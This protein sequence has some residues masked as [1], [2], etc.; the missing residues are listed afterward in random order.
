MI[1]RRIIVAIAFLCLLAF[2]IVASRRSVDL[3]PDTF[4]PA[5]ALDEFGFY[6]RRV[7][8]QAGIDFKHRP[9][10]LDARVSH[11]AKQIASV[12]AA[13][14]ICDFDNDGWNDIYLTNSGSGTP[15][16]LYHNKKDGTFEDV[17]PLVGI[18]DVNVKGTGFSM[19][20]SWGD[21]DNDGYDDMILYKWGRPELFRNI[22]GVRF[23]RITEGSG[24]P[25]WAN[26]NTAIWFDFNNDGLLDIFI[27]GYYREELDL[28]NLHTTKIMPES[29]K[30]A[31][32]GGRNYLLRN[33][34]NGKFEDVTT[35]YGLTSTKW[36]LSAAAVDLTGDG[37]PDLVLANDYGVDEFFVNERGEKFVER[38]KQT[39]MGHV[40]KSGM[41]VSFGDIENTG[42][43]GIYITN[44]SEEGILTQGNT[45]WKVESDPS[46]SMTF[47]NLA[48]LLG[49]EYSGWS[50]GAQFGDLNNDGY[51]DVY[52][53]NGFVSDNPN[54][55]Y[56]YDYSKITGGYNAI[57]GD[58]AN[59]PAMGDKSQS[60][61]QRD[62]VWINRG[63]VFEDATGKTSNRITLDGRSVAMADLWNRGVLDVVVANQNGSPLIYETT[64]APGRNWIDFELTGTVSNADAIGA[65]VIL[66]W[67]GRRQFQ[68]ITGGVGFSSQNQHR[69]HFGLGGA[70]AVDKVTIYWPSGKVTEIEKPAINQIHKIVEERSSD[71]E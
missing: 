34:G 53:T 25:E 45:F 23:E 5:A 50:Y 38:G 66:S 55:S 69:V 9:P 18:A 6:F 40:P 67:D 12:G 56:W 68:V 2:S 58:A 37:F 32:N 60:G 65:R 41:N 62:K 16:A 29:F 4:D 31:N 39:G 47:V 71:D 24:L 20:S 70:S 64:V 35:A 33:I 3:G 28:S 1:F 51:Q 19:G 15:N 22:K 8:Q 10:Q 59:W 52:V 14:S 30:Y 44:I 49:I 7:N 36:T 48:Q 46:N 54:E 26:S 43:P 61:Y 17:A 63:G 21:F 42:Q 27:G 11:I 57:I 13:V